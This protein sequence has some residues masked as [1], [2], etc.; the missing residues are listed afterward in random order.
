MP[1]ITTVAGR[2]TLK[3]RHEPYWH[4]VATG[5][6]LGFRK[7]TPDSVGKWIAYY[8]DAETGKKTKCSLGDFIELPA[9]Q[10]FT[11]A[12]AAA[13]EKFRH[14][15]MGGSSEVVTVAG[16]CKSYVQWLREHK[17]DA[18]ADDAQAR[19][20]RW[21][22]DTDLGRT[23][24]GKLRQAKVEKWRA[25]LKKTAVK[26]NRD[27]RETPV[28][29]ER[30]PSSVNRDMTSLRAALN[31][32]LKRRLVQTDVEWREALRPTKNADG[33][34]EVYLDRKQRRELIEQA[35]VDVA[36]LLRGLALLPLRPGALA[37]LTVASFDKGLSILRIGKD[38]AGGDRRITLPPTT[39]AF[40][41]AQTKGKTPAAPLFARAD[42]EFW[43]KDAWKKP[44]KAAA[45]A[46][47][48]PD[49]TTAYALRHSNITDLVTGGLDLLTVAQLAGT[50]VSMI[51][52]HYGHLQSQRAADALAALAL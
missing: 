42:G 6:Y 16:A 29:R 51:E 8:R 18:Q 10:R 44:I 12:Q 2:A 35:P 45:A 50:S 43:T 23:E 9:A 46:A 25:G 22:D 30:S 14:L 49:T 38:K 31:H 4:M 5:T 37:A 15:A 40:V 21:V 20:R 28:L 36:V 41:A 52:K 7:M 47:G 17:G 48:L 3:P 11:A 1:N 13:T 19:F 33:R 27:N 39:A 24:L 34:R 26:V 32:A